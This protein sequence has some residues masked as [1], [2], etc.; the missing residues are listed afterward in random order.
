M[1]LSNASENDIKKIA[2]K[3]V[4]RSKGRSRKNIKIEDLTG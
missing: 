4:Q 1:F 2:A 3:F